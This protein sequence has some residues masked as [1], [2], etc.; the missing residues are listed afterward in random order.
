MPIA[1]FASGL[2]VAAVPANAT[3]DTLL[4]LLPPPPPPHAVHNPTD[5]PSHTP[6]PARM[7][8]RCPML[9]PLGEVRL[10]FSAGFR[11]RRVVR[12]RPSLCECRPGIQCAKNHTPHHT[13]KGFH[14]RHLKPSGTFPF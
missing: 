4:A 7:T 13:R 5:P 3:V 1:A 10:D 6:P 8:S 14:G 9:I 2:P 11:R 12:L